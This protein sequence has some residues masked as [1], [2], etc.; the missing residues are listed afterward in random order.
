[1]GMF[2]VSPRQLLSVFMR[3][4]F[5][6]YAWLRNDGT[7]YY[8]GKGSNRR[9]WRKGSPTKE[10]VLILKQELCEQ[11]AFKHEVYM[12]SVF[13]RKDVGTGILHN[14]SDGGEKSRAGGRGNFRKGTKHGEETKRKIGLAHKGKKV[15]IETREK[16]R[17][18]SKGKKWWNNGIEQHHCH[19]R[20]GDEWNNGKLN[21]IGTETR[22]KLSQANKGKN[23]GK[24]WWNNGIE[25]RLCH[26]RPGEEWNN[27]RLSYNLNYLTEEANGTL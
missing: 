19:K 22:E 15:R 21:C 10:R 11:D 2:R 8:I 4:D 5:Y 6:T 9:A 20:P 13:G 7:P 25:Q 14:C 27:G 26:E 1:M 18:A 23:K 17:Q 16:L 3:K 24:K 12:I